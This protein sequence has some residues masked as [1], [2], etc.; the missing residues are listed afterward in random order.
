M[1]S[2][3]T[4]T[5]FKRALSFQ[6]SADSGRL[7]AR[8]RADCNSL[9]RPWNARCRIQPYMPTSFVSVVTAHPCRTFATLLLIFGLLAASCSNADRSLNASPT[10]EVASTPSRSDLAGTLLEEMKVRTDALLSAQFNLSMRIEGPHIS[11][12]FSQ[13][14]YMQSRER[15]YVKLTINEQVT[16]TLFDHSSACLRQGGDWVAIRTGD[17][18]GRNAIYRVEISPELGLTYS[19]AIEG[20]KPA[21]HVYGLLTGTKARNIVSL[22]GGLSD[23]APDFIRVGYFF[24]KDDY[25]LRNVTGSYESIVA[26][27]PAVTNFTMRTARIG[28]DIRFPDGVPEHCPLPDGRPS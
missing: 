25:I 7:P 9:P 3:S 10:V 4:L 13:Q 20:G 12:L 23:V 22:L 18:D 14:T 28:E 16:E 11:Q 26:G 6:Q 17:D 15:I 2:G 1:N 21:Y 5:I 19:E 24:G 8:S 27:R